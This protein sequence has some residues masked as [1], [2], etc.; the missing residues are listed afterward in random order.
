MEPTDQ[1]VLNLVFFANFVENEERWEVMI[2]FFKKRV[3]LMIVAYF[4]NKASLGF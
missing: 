2:D 1:D 4:F 3:K